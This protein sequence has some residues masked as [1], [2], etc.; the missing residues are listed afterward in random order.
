MSGDVSILYQ[1]GSGGFALYYYLLL[2]GQYH[3]DSAVDWQQQYPDSLIDNP[4]SW[5][6]FETW[7]NNVSLK[8]SNKFPRLFLICNPCWN[9]PMI[10]QNLSIVQGTFKI[11]LYTD[12]KLQL[13]M[14]WEK[15][16]YWFTDVSKKEFNAPECNKQYMRNIITQAHN[17]LDP[18]IERVRKLFQPN[19]ELRLEH[20]LKTQHIPGITS[21]PN[22]RQLEFLTHWTK[23]QPSKAQKLLAR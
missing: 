4:N 17:G 20:F 8:K 11:M 5:K 15:Q 12:L 18:M 21:A 13:R 23:I 10:E 6:L 3:A 2:S 14:A 9:P 7:P 22:D 16:A 1:G 19:V